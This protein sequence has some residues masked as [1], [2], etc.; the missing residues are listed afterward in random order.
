MK[1]RGQA[2]MEF[3]MTYGWAILIVLVAISALWLFG[4]FNRDV[5]SK[6]DLNIP[7]GCTQVIVGEYGAV[8]RINTGE[9]DHAN[10]VS[11]KIN[12]Q[13]CPEAATSEPLSAH[14]VSDII[15]NG[16]RLEEGEPV[17]GEIKL[18]YYKVG[19]TIPHTSEG[20]ITGEV[21]H[22]PKTA[23]E[24]TTGP[25]EYYIDEKGPELPPPRLVT[26]TT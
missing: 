6:C 20:T 5:P 8:L 22:L 17:L 7:F 11:I 23:G 14:Q 26:V 18:T 24:I 16:I 3:L 1:K 25:G 4:A 19:A 15:C 13:D 12:G 2:A 21:K 10:V 9:V